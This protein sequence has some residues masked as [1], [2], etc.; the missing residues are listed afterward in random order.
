MKINESVWQVQDESKSPIRKHW[1][2]IKTATI[3]ERILLA[4]RSL[5]SY[6]LSNN[7]KNNL[8]RK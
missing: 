7:V 2:Y 8:T 5:L 4:H 1:D 6:I 3:E